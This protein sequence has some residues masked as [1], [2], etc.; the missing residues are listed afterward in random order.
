[1]KRSLYSSAFEVATIR[2][3]PQPNRKVRL[4]ALHTA[5]YNTYCLPQNKVYMDLRTDG[6]SGALLTLQQSEM[7]ELEN[8]ESGYETAPENSP[9]LMRLELQVKKL[10]G[11][12]YLVPCGMGRL[13]EKTWV[14]MRAHPG[15]IVPGNTIFWSI[16]YYLNKL[17]CSF[18]DLTVPASLDLQSDFLFKGNIDVS[19]LETF[20][21]EKGASKIPFMY[22]E[23][24]LNA[25]GGQPI[26]LSNLRQVKNVL[27]KFKI[28]L[29][30]DATRILE[31]SFFIKTRETGYLEKSISEIILETC[32]LA[33]ACTL[34]A[35]KNFA[36]RGIGLILMRDPA[37]YADTCEK[38]QLEGLHP[39]M[40]SIAALGRSISEMIENDQYAD[41]RVIEIQK[42]GNALLENGIPVV[43]PLGG[44]AIYLDLKSFFPKLSY[45]HFPA[46]ALAAY[47]YSISGIR[48]ARGFS[49]S[50]EQ[51]ALGIDM[52][53]M[54]FPANRY[55]QG[56]RQDLV[57]AL[58]R[59]FKDRDQIKGLKPITV[60]GRPSSFSEAF[61]TPTWL[62]VD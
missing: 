55:T 40:A 49:P 46:Q 29:Y 43:R 32:S 54:A 5:R 18:H 34:S 10:F 53:R 3:S 12:P 51:K 39:T 59:A 11:F 9:S 31:N 6:S 26:S 28:P 13:A 14:S 16:K 25:V 44:H 42:L 61:E 19:S 58:A 52:L 8:L 41:V 23:L 21:L 56:H 4:E 57:V 50:V 48:L 47:V 62:P 38:S 24:C 1:M 27:D 33:D 37:H 45:Q 15:S 22:I 2:P 7:L 36:G 30:L 35:Q 60:P 20:I 17:G